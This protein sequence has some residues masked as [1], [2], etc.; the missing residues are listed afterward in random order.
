MDDLTFEYLRPNG[1][2]LVKMACLREA[3]KAYVQT[4]EMYLPEGPD[5]TYALRKFREVAMW[6][7]VAITRHSDG[8]PRDLQIET[9]DYPP[10]HPAPGDLGSVPP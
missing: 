2:Q 1:D 7:N 9:P 8:S 5:R 6:A 10:N 4:L 3:A